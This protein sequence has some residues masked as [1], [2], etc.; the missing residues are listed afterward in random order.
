MFGRG[1][2]DS[3]FWCLISWYYSLSVTHLHTIRPD[4]SSATRTVFRNK[5]REETNITIYKN[6]YIDMQ[7]SY[8]S[9]AVFV[10]Q[11]IREQICSH[12]VSHAFNQV[13]SGHTV[14]PEHQRR[15]GLMMSLWVWHIFIIFITA[16][17][18][19]WTQTQEVKQRGNLT[20]LVCS[21]LVSGPDGF[22]CSSP[23]K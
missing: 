18:P 15:R 10:S 8:K 2:P 16:G 19:V 4:V 12:S 11:C 1:S 6:S 3:F 20:P 13:L 14:K 22:Y 21:R 5:E 17:R 23:Y 7:Q 9:R